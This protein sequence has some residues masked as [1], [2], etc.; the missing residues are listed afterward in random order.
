MKNGLWSDIFRQ[1]YQLIHHITPSN[2]VLLVKWYQNNI[3]RKLM[4]VLLLFL[5]W[6]ID[7]LEIWKPWHLADEGNSI[8]ALKPVYAY[9][10]ICNIDIFNHW[11][12]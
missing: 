4:E 7:K 3:G 2:L 12:I 1:N 11:F 9:I 10:Y 5:I 6:Q 8:N